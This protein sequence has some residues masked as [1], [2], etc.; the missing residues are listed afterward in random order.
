M[1]RE[2]WKKYKDED[3]NEFLPG[4]TSSPYFMGGAALPVIPKTKTKE[5]IEAA[6]KKAEER[7][8][9]KIDMSAK[10]EQTVS[11]GEEDDPYDPIDWTGG[12]GTSEETTSKGKQ[13]MKGGTTPKKGGTKKK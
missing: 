6:K 11:S 9:K 1:L 2:Y 8:K 7:K 10:A 3:P 12:E 5:E 4:G 13:P